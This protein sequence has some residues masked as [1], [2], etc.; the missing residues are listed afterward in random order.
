[1]RGRRGSTRAFSGFTVLRPPFARRKRRRATLSYEGRGL[2]L[3]RRL[4]WKRARSAAD[5]ARI[6][7][8]APKGIAAGA[9]YPEMAMRAIDA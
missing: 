4:S 3:I 5:L 9:R 7:T 1:M 6:E 2:G 8:V